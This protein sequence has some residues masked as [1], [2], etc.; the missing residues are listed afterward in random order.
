MSSTRRILVHGAGALGSG[1]V[2]TFSKAG[3]I[4]FATD[5]Q[6]IKDN[7]CNFSF[8]L[9]SK[10]SAKE[11]VKETLQ[12]LSDELKNEKLDCVISTAGGF[13][14][15]NIKSEDLFDHIDTLFQCNTLSAFQ[16][17]VF[18]SQYLRNEG[19]L[20][21]TGAYSAIHP[22]PNMLSYGITKAST[23]HLIKSLSRSKQMPQNSI[24]IGILPKVIDTP[25]NRVAMP[26]EDFSNWTPIDYIAKQIF[27]WNTKE[28]PTNGN[29][30][31]FDTKK[32]VTDVI[33]TNF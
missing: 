8:Q 12:W 4:V 27:D 31:T 7:N 23:H 29:F 25:A 20:I 9:D 13:N 30:Y 15:D 26:K 33:V 2:E 21:L 1:V 18:A 16:A 17:S 3:W 10:K 24:V 11:N 19:L 32:G 5:I 6:P 22:T 28:K 14:M